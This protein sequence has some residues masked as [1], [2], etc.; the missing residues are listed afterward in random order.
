MT[1]SFIGEIRAFPYNFNPLGWLYCDGS[2]QN[3]MQYQALYAVIGITYGGNGKTTFGLPDLNSRVAMGLNGGS[4]PNGALSPV[5]IGAK[6]GSEG[7]AINQMTYPVH[8]HL[9]YSEAA[10]YAKTAS[11]YKSKPTANVSYLSRYLEPTSP[12]AAAAILAYNPVTPSY[13]PPAPPPAS[14][15]TSPVGMAQQMLGAV[16]KGG[17]PHENRQP[18]VAIPFFICYDGIWPERP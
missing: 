8:N 6:G 3:I 17:Q 13:T 2:Q 18:F 16:T 9:V 4:H 7:V 12:T 10:A 15:P 1:D 11:S 5:V 14:A